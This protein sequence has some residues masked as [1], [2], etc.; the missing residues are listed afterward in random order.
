MASYYRV[1]G[2]SRHADL[3]EIRQA[4]WSLSRHVRRECRTR[5]DAVRL[6]EIRRAYDIL[7]DTIRRR[8]YDERCADA[9]PSESRWQDWAWQPALHEDDVALDFPSMSTTACIVPRI[10]REFFGRDPEAP[11]TKHTTRVELTPQQAHDGARVPVE[12]TVR[13][14]CPVCGGR[15][16]TWSEPCGVCFGTGAGSLSQELRL[17]IPPGVRNGTCL[18][19]SITPP[20]AA[21]TRVELYIAIQ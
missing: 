21:Q 6:H 10:R 2:V 16:E 3:D 11:E 1:L 19:F 8:S 7:S 15:G 13:P 12:L 20:F 4:F 18:T 17:P 9:P 5:E 14:V